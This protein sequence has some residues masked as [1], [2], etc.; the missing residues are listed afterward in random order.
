MHA[1]V[2]IWAV[3]G[4]S[5]LC[6]AWRCVYWKVF[7]VSTVHVF[8]FILGLFFELDLCYSTLFVFRAVFSR[9]ILIVSFRDSNP[10]PVFSIPGFGIGEFLIPGSRRDYGIPVVSDQKPLL[11]S[12]LT[13]ILLN[14]R[15]CPGVTG[16]CIWLMLWS[17]G[18]R[19]INSLFSTIAPFERCP[20]W[21]R[22]LVLGSSPLTLSFRAG[23]CHPK[24]V[25]KVF[26]WQMSCKIRAFCSFF[27][28][29]K[30][31]D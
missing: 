11:L 12:I 27:I 29:P 9:P 17:N 1:S 30:S 6:R 23:N 2:S 20:S 26:L 15:F 19:R 18:R 13:Y 3:V 22:I 31:R 25:E 14:L 28:S 7:K 10:G 4:V 24:F 21:W 16:L 8:V 5:Q